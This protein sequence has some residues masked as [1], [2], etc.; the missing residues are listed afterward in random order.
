ML[1]PTLLDL[2]GRLQLWNARS[3][4]L[5]MAAGQSASLGTV[6]SSDDED[7]RSTPLCPCCQAAL[8]VF[9][10]AEAGHVA[11]GGPTRS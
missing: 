8:I 1:S 4:V 6:T 10:S 3:R 5:L 2:R 11:A 7:S 9:A